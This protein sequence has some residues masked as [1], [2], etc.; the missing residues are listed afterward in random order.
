[1]TAFP[2][3]ASPPR[4]A[5]RAPEFGV[6]TTE[7]SLDQILAEVDEAA[8]QKWSEDHLSLGVEVPFSDG[9]CDCGQY[10]VGDNRCSCGSR[11]ISISVVGDLLTGFYYEIEAY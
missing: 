2:G 10:M 5:R 1:M 6:S 11:R 9:I 4:P 3:R 8:R 7:K